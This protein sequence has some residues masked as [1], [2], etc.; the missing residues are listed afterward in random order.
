MKARKV[1]KKILNRM[2]DFIP[3]EF[4]HNYVLLQSVYGSR[5][6]VKVAPSFYDGILRWEIADAKKKAKQ[7]TVL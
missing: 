5:N 7:T 4:G 2:I 6:L 1:K 3:Y